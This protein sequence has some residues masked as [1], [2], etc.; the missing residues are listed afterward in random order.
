MCMLCGA[1]AA[2]I[3]IANRHASETIWEGGLWDTPY[4]VAMCVFIWLSLLF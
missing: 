3:A 2:A 4:A 1:S